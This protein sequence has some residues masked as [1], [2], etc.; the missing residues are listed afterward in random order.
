M[1]NR[2]I[3][4]TGLSCR[5]PESDSPGEFF[6]NL[7]S[8]KDLVTADSRRWKEQIDGIPP[9]FGKIKQDLGLFDNKFFTVH[10]KQAEKLDPQAR[11]LLEVSYEALV[12]AG[13]CLEQI[14]K[15]R[16]GVYV[17]ACDSD[18][19]KIWG[20]DKD[21]MTGYENTGCALSMLANRLSFFYD[22]HGPS[23]TI[24]TAC[25]SSLVAFHRAVQDLENGV[26]DSALVGGATIILAPSATIGFH[27]LKMLS[28]DGACKSF[29]QSANGFA[30][31]EGISIV[32]LTTSPKTRYRPYAKVLGTGV[33]NGGWNSSGITF[34]SG[35]MQKDLYQTVCKKAKLDPKEID[36]I[37]AH[38]TGT[39]AGDGEELG[40]IYDVYGK[41]NP[42]LI[43]GSVKSNMGHCEGNSG[44]AGLIKVLIG[45]DQE[46]LPPNLHLHNPN[47]QLKSMRVM[48][49]A[50][51]DWKGSKVA[52]SSF[53]FGGTN[54]H[55]ILEKCVNHPS[56]SAKPVLDLTLLAHRT[57]EGLYRLKSCCPK[58]TQIP[59][60][61][62][63]SK[64]PYREVLELPDDPEVVNIA[65]SQDKIYLACSGNGSQWKGMGLQLA[66]TFARF[67]KILEECGKAVDQDLIAVLQKGC[68]GALENTLGLV[69]IQIGLIELI[70][71]FGIK[72]DRIAGFF[73]HS[74]GEI[75]CSYLDGITSLEET[76]KIAHA[77]GVIANRI[78][79]QGLMAS[80]GLS[81]EEALKFIQENQVEGRVC[82]ACVNSPRNVTISGLK[83]EVL[84]LVDK[85]NQKDLFCRVLETHGK[86]YHSFLFSEYKVDLE[87]MLK[88]CLDG[89]KRDRS[90]RW[91]SSVSELKG[92]LFD[93]SYHVEGVLRQVDFIQTMQNIPQ[94]SIIVE[95]GPHSVLKN[96]IKDNRP[97][98]KYVSFMKK[99]TDELQSFKEGLAKLWKF[100]IQ[101]D[102]Q[103]G[104]TVF[105]ARDPLDVRKNMV[106]WDHSERFPIPKEEDFKE[107]SQTKITFNLSE[108]KDQFLMRHVID[109]KIILP[110]T[111]YL[112]AMWEAF[113][114]VHG[115]TLA[116]PVTYHFTDF[117]I[118]QAVQ[119]ENKSNCVLVIE[120]LGNQYE[121]QFK[122][123]IVAKVKIELAPHK[124]WTP[125]QFSIDGNYF[126]TD[127][128]Y[129][130]FGVK[131]YQH[132]GEFRNVEKL[133]HDYENNCN[134]CHVRW[135]DNWITFLDGVLQC[136]LLQPKKLFEDLR[137]PTRMRSVMI[138]PQIVYQEIKAFDGIACVRVDSDVGSILT[139]G[140]KFD[141]VESK[142]LIQTDKSLKKRIDVHLAEDI[143]YYG[144]SQID[145]PFAEEYF[146]NFMNYSAQVCR[147]FIEENQLSEK[148]HYKR[149][150]EAFSRWNQCA[151]IDPSKMAPY[152]NRA[153]CIMFKILETAYFE[154]PKEFLDSPLTVITQ[155]PAH[156]QL[157]FQDPIGDSDKSWLVKLLS[158]VRENTKNDLN[159][160]EFGTG[161]GGLTR[162]V[163][164][165]LLN[166]RFIATDITETIQITPNQDTAHIN[167]EYAKFDLNNH[168]QYGIL[169]KY[170]VDLILAANSI[171]TAN[172]LDRV[173]ESIFKGLKEGGFA[174]IKEVTSPISLPL[175]GMDSR[176]WSFEDEREF[177]L[178][179]SQESWIQKLTQ[180]G[181]EVI[182]YIA[183]RNNIQTLF[184][185]RKPLQVKMEVL[186]APSIDGFEN[187]SPK[188]LNRDVPTLLVARGIEQSG[189]F[190]FTRCLNQEV[191]GNNFYCVATDQDLTPAQI[192][193]IEKFGLKSN[194]L[195]DQRLGAP[196]SCKIAYQEKVEPGT[197]F[198]YSFS[199]TG[200]FASGKWENVAPAKEVLCQVHFAALN[201]KDV[202]VASGKLRKDAFSGI[203]EKGGIGFEFSGCDAQGNRYMGSVSHSIGTQVDANPYRLFPIPDYLSYEEAAT[204]PVVYGT[205]FHALFDRAKIK[206]GQTILIHAGTGGVGLA[207][208]QVCLSLGCK[209]F[210]TCHS[211]KRSI[212]RSL[213]PQIEERS[214]LDSRSTEFEAEIMKQTKGKGVDIVLNSLSGDKLQASVRCLAPE[215][216]FIEIGKVDLMNHSPLDMKA[217]LTCTTVHGIDL[218]RVMSQKEGGLSIG[219]HLKEG[220]EK[221]WIKPLPYHLFEYH[222]IPEAFRF[223]ASSKHIGKVLI[224]MRNFNRQTVVEPFQF[225]FY[226]DPKKEGY[227]LI[228]G[229]LGGFGL[230]L[231]QWLFNRGVKKFLITSR[232]GV[233][234]AEQE[235]V[236]YQLRQSGA[237]V[238]VSTKNV[239]DQKETQ[240]LI[241]SVEGK[242][243]SVFH[244]AMVLD[245]VLFKNMTKQQWEAAVYIK[246]KGARNLDQ[247]TRHLPL[248][249]FVVF[250][251]LASRFGNIGQS[252]YAV[253][254]GVMEEICRL[255]VKEGRHALAIQ[256]GILADAGFVASNPDLVQGLGNVYEPIRMADALRFVDHVLTNQV[257]SHSVYY[258]S[259]PLRKS[260]DQTIKMTFEMVIQQI[261]NIV[262]IDLLKCNENDTLEILGSD[263]LQV[264]EIQT[265][266][267]KAIQEVLPLKKIGA[268]KIGEL[269]KLIKDK[270]GEEQ[271]VE[272][273]LRMET[274][275]QKEALLINLNT[276]AS[277]HEIIYLFLGYGTP[278]HSVKIPPN[279]GMNL[280]VVA[281]HNVDSFEILA[282]AIENDIKANG[283][284]K[285]T[286]ITHS[287]G[288]NVA[289]AVLAQ[290]SVTIDKLIAI[291][292][293]NEGL[294]SEI[295]TLATAAVPEDIFETGYKNSAFFVKDH[296]PIKQ[297][298]MQT[299]LLSKSL[300]TKYLPPHLVIVPQNDS[301]CEKPL[302]AVEI[303]G[304]HNFESIKMEEV[305]AYL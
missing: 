284:K 195:F 105:G 34:P 94:N 69:A 143:L 21:A 175:W 294:F 92:R 47:P 234:S 157:A 176:V 193:Q 5:L 93:S 231:M 12:D 67:K 26:C 118:F 167:L 203:A 97:D 262:K 243:T 14:K 254:N 130:I 33:N 281:W 51:Q 30:R 73:G 258:M 292:L 173:L 85:A 150:L 229:G 86:A 29:D 266:L 7:L 123:E 153:E 78:E 223:M 2:P 242:I 152:R 110:A 161:T 61:E 90:D 121:L 63:K 275:T 181:F 219:K 218:T 253:G 136:H 41:R 295:A 107:G 196:C 301:L 171:H 43:I 137:I 224:D 190:G 58:G 146:G 155:H 122:G 280:C 199:S 187:W 40:A 169:Q 114:K 57:H 71:S 166:D 286:F 237:E 206:P 91:T 147:R 82:V 1:L 11:L 50:L 222:Q 83:E 172:H 276:D 268:M 80:I 179:I 66:A 103:Q 230:S 191:E 225:S 20:R 139:S 296:L 240:E 197:G 140:V 272:A 259:F 64:L 15:S 287:A 129:R 158:I 265:V 302:G 188:Y 75:I 135:A 274:E 23:E 162:L 49:E 109:G 42:D 273:D 270:I 27:R 70:H 232:R 124:I 202:M 48:T 177:G 76:M 255:R 72:E 214:I 37:E 6:Q 249:H 163:A 99:N 38:G 108:E 54:A 142:E 74:A 198:H 68:E 44:L 185:F 252:N 39:V 156:A 256:W 53:G 25:S 263:S 269:K 210:T 19:R 17:G 31:S 111:S 102:L 170:D 213:Y 290:N 8:K 104:E 217:L 248:R 13:L 285:I 160:L 154:T 79:T 89:E 125:L 134:F 221:K 200:D 87:K 95:I 127:N 304:N 238:I 283:Y 212:L 133:K 164:P 211:S 126:D 208:I 77:R 113:R 59:N 149:V 32:V 151:P 128:L 183:D 36:Y 4:I 194:V 100:G 233:T 182:S 261:C 207:A 278:H 239:A 55:I 297:V 24:D 96:L 216:H 88:K 9:R 165:F 178:W 28:P 119:I 235:R 84:A 184:F 236:L 228:T 3:Y 132:Q 52:V 106:S 145:E 120:H 305:Y 192:R 117:E 244:L 189:V 180:A 204:I 303:S 209:V 246:A 298:K 18:A 201:F 81:K 299:F 16:M 288:Y 168:D 267:I 46:I 282:R 45:L 22:L 131:G 10:G 245:D 264:V 159:I 101:I 251:S 289:K 215:G 260:Q 35:E 250:S 174:I 144:R 257:N 148:G 56:I 247:L 116:D 138:N 291:S 241:D 65:A 205:V 141:H 277:S 300:K 115:L 293:V 226:Q 271:L 112:C 220:L 186:D 98:L 62:N 227:Y 279:R 60:R